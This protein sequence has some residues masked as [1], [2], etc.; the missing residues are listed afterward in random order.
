[1]DDCVNTCKMDE[2]S[3]DCRKT[4]FVLYYQL[5]KRLNETAANRCSAPVGPPVSMV[6]GA[7]GTDGAIG[8]PMQKADILCF[9]WRCA[10]RSFHFIHLWRK[11]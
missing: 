9:F 11:G 7:S 5:K 6:T 8:H 4:C 2:W 3:F 1:M 10:V